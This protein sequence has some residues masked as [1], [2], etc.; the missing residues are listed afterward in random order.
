MPVLKRG[1]ES[2]NSKVDC[3]TPHIQRDVCKGT[4]GL[5]KLAA[6]CLSVVL[7]LG[8]VLQSCW[9]AR[10]VRPWALFR[11]L[12][13]FSLAWLALFP[14]CCMETLLLS[15]R[16]PLS[17]ALAVIIIGQNHHG[18][19]LPCKDKIGKES[20]STS[21]PMPAMGCLSAIPQLLVFLNLLTIIFYDSNFGL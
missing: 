1:Q 15:N 10:S 7:S 14:F 4:G 13:L 18:D 6:A 11:T 17:R 8:F 9:A 3:N 2:C 21:F 16:G 19:W 12:L 20:S 5:F